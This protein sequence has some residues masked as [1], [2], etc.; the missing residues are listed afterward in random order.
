MI[1]AESFLQKNLYIDKNRIVSRIKEGTG[2]PKKLSVAQISDTS[3][4]L[5][6]VEYKFQGKAVV[7]EEK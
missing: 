2:L 1:F 6:S 5:S 7:N 4:V 3:I